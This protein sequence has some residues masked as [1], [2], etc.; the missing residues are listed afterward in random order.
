MPPC[1]VLIF[2]GSTN[3]VLALGRTFPR[4]CTVRYMA[5]EEYQE[6]KLDRET[7]LVVVFWSS[8]TSRQIQAIKR[9]ADTISI[10]LVVLAEDMPFLKVVRL[11]HS[12]VTG[13]FPFP[14][15]TMEH[16]WLS[17]IDRL[18][19]R[20]DQ[21][22][23]N[24]FLLTAQGEWKKGLIDMGRKAIRKLALS[25][26]TGETG[27]HRAKKVEVACEMEAE[28]NPMPADLN[29]QL[30]GRLSI[31]YAGKKLPVFPGRKKEMILAYLLYH[32]DQVFHREQLMEKFWPDCESSSARNSLNVTIHAIR[33]YLAS[34]CS[35]KTEFLIFQRESYHWN[36]DLRLLTDVQL[37]LETWRN[38]H[39]IERS[40]GVEVLRAHLSK[41]YE[42][43]R[44]DLLENLPYADWC[45][46]EREHL[47]E[48]LIQICDRLSQIHFERGEFRQVTPY[49]ERMLAIDPC[50]EEAYRMLMVCYA[51][52]GK[53][54]LALRQFEK[55]KRTL[56]KELSIE[57]S[58]LTR[59]TVLA[60]QEGR[61]PSLHL[62]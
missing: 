21:K 24:S 29:V 61:T 49:C 13:I 45:Q 16:D 20:P 52:G 43:Y 58:Q 39:Q 19:S 44:G 42:W 7:G 17:M 14:L 50:L 9:L 10:P 48:I 25:G 36:P 54:N 11:V 33:N 51:R 60:I 6:D 57:P 37:F 40:E 22:V 3:N 5:W 34:F 31:T 30:F 56:R 23:T 27:S 32:H 4:H 46:E 62:E 18:L 38:R 59:D 1:N 15:G 35:A 53:R 41:A 2:G 26:P 28:A 55:C 47:R 8:D 12:G